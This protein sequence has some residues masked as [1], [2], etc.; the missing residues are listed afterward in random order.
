MATTV[1]AP[2][3]R[4]VL[5]DVD[6]RT[7]PW[8]DRLPT[9]L[10]A[11]TFL[12]VLMA[13]SAY[14]RT[15][16]I[17]GQF[18][19]DE[20]ITTGIS[21]HPLAQIPGVLRHD[22]SPPLFY[23]LLHFWM[24]AFGSSEATTHSLS[25][26]FGLLTIPIGMWAGWT[27]FGRRAGL[28]AA[29]LF[30]FSAFLTEYAQET[31]MYEL[32]GLLGLLATVG[33]MQGFVNRRRPY[34][35]LFAVS[36]ALMYYTHSWGIFFAGGSLCALFPVY[37]ASDDKRRLLR[38][39]AL[40]FIASGILYLPWLPNFIYQATHTGDPWAPT[41]RLG[42]PVLLSRDLMGGDRV[43]VALVI[44]A[45]VGFAPLATKRLRRTREATA[46]WALVLLPTCTLLLAWVASQITPAFV[47]RYFAPVLAP[48]LLLGAWGCARAKVLG[49]IMV[50]LT[51]VF[52]Y[53]PASYTPQYKS[54]MRDVGGIMTPLLHPGDL[55]VVSQPEQTPLAWYYLPGGLNFANTIGRVKDPSYMN[56]VDALKHL[57]HAN[58]QQT[59]G[60]LLASLKPGQ[61]LLYVRPMPEGAQN[62]EASWT[63]LVRRRS[64]Q[65][66]ALLAAD[67]NLQLVATAPNYYRGACCVAD[68][69]ILYKLR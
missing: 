68:S 42:A 54:D 38:D 14:L 22:G 43:T 6:F 62:W 2:P 67:Q 3:R 47:A 24:Q 21:L 12:I 60:P 33:F 59:L 25:L 29:V 64:A 48:I 63:Q 15:R 16:Y 9:W 32:M 39:A 28:M 44:A 5:P 69:A 52:L 37:R 61:Q 45:I 58:P 49:V 17:S 4:R 40:A 30:A 55:V 18:W 19:M 65:W 51:V 13:A 56:W 35:I 36:L 66:G 41:P 27:L 46:L 31:R 34:V 8:I 20:A 10:S 57:Q 1:E 23:L 53:N 50:V 26:L 11:G 7:P